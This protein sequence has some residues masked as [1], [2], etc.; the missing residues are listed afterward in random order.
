MIDIYITKQGIPYL[1][2]F[3]E[4][5]Y[6]YDK[7]EDS[8][9]ILPHLEKSVELEEGFTLRS[10]FWM[11][12]T[13][14]SLQ[15]LD[16]FSSDFIEEYLRCPSEECVFDDDEISYLSINRLVNY[17]NLGYEKNEEDDW[18][19]EDSIDFCGVGEDTNYAIEFSPLDKL[20]DYE[21][22]IDPAIIV[23]EQSGD[24]TDYSDITEKYQD[25]RGKDDT[26]SLFEF[27]RYIIWELSF[28]GTPEDRENKNS[29]IQ[30]SI[31]KAMEEL[32]EGE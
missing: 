11:L 20:L 24:L 31:D 15:L 23:I 10:Y 30:E 18:R 9:Q 26:F 17:E 1:R 13:Y 16:K 27:V 22:K 8:D 29:E 4:G 7:F 6:Y 28:C 21:V 25:F 5:E 2:R 32:G 19:I 14:P 3:H 12:I